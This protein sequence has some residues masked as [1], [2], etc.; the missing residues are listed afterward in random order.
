ME[1]KFI[2]VE[3][4]EVNDTEQSIVGWGSKP[5]P[6]RDGELI[7]STAWKLDDYRKNPVLMLC[8]DYSTPPVG[9]V[10]WVKSDTSGLKFKARFA[11]T[12][13][14]KEIYQ[15]YK[16]GIMSAFSV[17]FS[18]NQNGVVNNPTD[19]KYKGLKKVYKDINL[20]EISCVPIPSCSEAL[21][22]YV[23][24]GKIQTKQLKDEMD[25]VVEIIGKETVIVSDVI[26]KELE[27]KADG[28][29]SDNVPNEE[30][31]AC[32]GKDYD[33]LE[34]CKECKSREECES[35]VEKNFE[36]TSLKETI[37]NLET[38]L[39]TSEKT[40]ADLE[41]K[42][43]E[44]ED[45]VSKVTD[46]TGQPSVYDITSAVSRALGEYSNGNPSPEIGRIP[47]RYMVDLFPN[48]YPNGSIIYYESGD[49]PSFYK[50]N[51][52]YDSDGVVTFE[53]TVEEVVQS[54]VFN[55]YGE[56]VIETKEIEEIETKAG[57][58]LSD[59]NR[60]LIT[61]TVT[62]MNNAVGALNDLLAATEIVV[63]EKEIEEIEIIQKDPV[64]EVIEIETK[65][66]TTFEIDEDEIRMALTKA[67]SG[68]LK[69]SV[70]EGVVLAL[71]KA[72][73]K[74]L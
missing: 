58:V 66:I 23:K 63:E 32:M 35:K 52:Y 73:G 41:T 55:K 28:L 47:Y 14:G 7:E 26:E 30:E 16:E 11:N 68:V 39:G 72:S 20:L 46:T 2:V 49:V 51:Y 50:V 6:D 33:T 69:G 64:E 54:W 48:N 36:V 4:S 1:K 59:K 5:I 19:I 74:V 10:L 24:A 21:I 37:A 25:H 43:V 61:S 45:I 70:E 27:I 67:I 12:E 13:R 65:E 40:V 17:G 31:N 18:P 57:R 53:G 22:E 62:Q 44:L 38:S 8:H 9:K 71:K 34:E 60:K 15:L 42:I 56:Q 29:N 3:K